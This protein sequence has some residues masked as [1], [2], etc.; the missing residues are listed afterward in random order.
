M[1]AT[2]MKRRRALPIYAGLAALLLGGGAAA[3][4][5]GVG[6]IDIPGYTL[7]SPSEAA[8][9]KA[10]EDA[11]RR[12][13]EES[14][15]KA[16]EEEKRRADA[17]A[18]RRDEEE[19]KRRA[20]EDAK[21]RAEDDKR[22]AAEEKRR[23]EDEKRRADADAKRR[24]E[25]EAKRR[26]EEDKRRAEEDK[27][28]ADEDKRRAEE[29]AK[30]RADSDSARR[31]EDD[32]KRRAEEEA[33]RRADARRAEEEAKR[34][35][36]EE[37]KRRAED[38]KRRAEDEAKRR[39]EDEAK[40]RAEEERADAERRARQASPARP[41][42]YVADRNRGILY[43]AHKSA[44]IEASAYAAL[45]RLIADARASATFRITLIAAAERNEG[46][47]AEV[48]RLRLARLAAIRAWLVDRGIPQDRIRIIQGGGQGEGAEHR[49]VSISLEASPATADRP[50]TDR[51]GTD[52]PA[53]DRPGAS[54]PERRYSQ[55]ELTLMMYRLLKG[56]A[57]STNIK[58]EGDAALSSGAD[59]PAI[60]VC[61]NWAATTPEKASIGGAYM[62]TSR[63]GYMMAERALRGCQQMSRPNCECVVID[64][65]G[66]NALRLPPAFAQKYARQ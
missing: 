20:D 15:R 23:A 45:E 5:L 62:W 37:A 42:W 44:Q 9:R 63:G 16:A 58:T 26:A 55:A 19:A 51:P 2:P 30:R 32:A 33:K 6:G 13:E 28:R 66:G 34:R 54:E 48:V 64:V 1:T 18:A 12:A 39:A 22:R 59:V 21:R 24:A 41:S 49:V 4:Y 7:N 8:Q 52:R 29:E 65:G 11:K 14:R 50:G 61:V 60:A 53:A 36:D 31:A 56:A 57:M 35:A 38:E 3:A 17:D 47:G 40:R 25:E 27:R 10:E 46:T 43:F